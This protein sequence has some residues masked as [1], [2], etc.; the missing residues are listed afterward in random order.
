MEPH[1][2]NLQ[3]NHG[4]IFGKLI[5]E[6][7]ELLECKSLEELIKQNIVAERKYYFNKTISDVIYKNLN[8]VN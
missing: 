3:S 6:I 5:D 8:G 4:E 2:Q 1:T 7:E